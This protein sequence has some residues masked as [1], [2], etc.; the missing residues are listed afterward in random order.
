MRDIDKKIVA[1]EFL[2]LLSATIFYLV[3]VF[4]LS[5][6]KQRSI[7]E[8]WDLEAEIRRTIHQTP[9]PQRLKLYYFITQHPEIPKDD[10]EVFGGM[11]SR[12][13]FIQRMKD[14]QKIFKVYN[15]F[16]HKDYIQV[17]RT[18]FTSWQLN[19]NESEE[20]LSE[21]KALE[22]KRDNIE[23]SFIYSIEDDA[24]FYGVFWIIFTLLF[25]LRYLFYSTKWSIK[26]LNN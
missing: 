15:Y 9:L 5:F 4:T 7:D 6:I 12:H 1:R 25:F 10:H 24:I 8:A 3:I 20:S 16:L 14:E 21:L 11:E 18:T 17:D 13:Q 26:Q 2:F 22:N 19:D 23:D